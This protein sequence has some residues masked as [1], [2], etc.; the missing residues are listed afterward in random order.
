[1]AINPQRPVDTKTRVELVPWWVRQGESLPPLEGEPT[2]MRFVVESD[3][4]LHEERED[5]TVRRFAAVRAADNPQPG[6]E[7]DP[8][9][10]FVVPEMMEDV[11]G[12]AMNSAP[13]WDDT[14]ESVPLP[15]W[16]RRGAGLPW[17]PKGLLALVLLALAAVWCGTVYILATRW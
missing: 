15:S 10:E 13:L 8:A 4:E 7:P 5:T 12:D 6:S 1:M 3:P 9:L 2:Q 17:Q 11:K 16:R 14:S